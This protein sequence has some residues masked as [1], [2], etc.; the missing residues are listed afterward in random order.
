M[1]LSSNK[2]FCLENIL[3]SLHF[4]GLDQSNFDKWLF[5]TEVPRIFEVVQL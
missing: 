2:N 4:F 5:D 3:D 1:S